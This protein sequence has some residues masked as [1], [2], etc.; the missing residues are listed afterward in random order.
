MATLAHLTENGAGEVWFEGPELYLPMTVKHLLG[1]TINSLLKPVGVRL[2]RIAEINHLQREDRRKFLELIR[3]VEGMFQ[4]ANLS[5]LPSR[6]GR[7]E[8][9]AELFGTNVSEAL[10][11][12]EY[13]HRA[14]RLKGDVCEFGV[15]QGATSTLMANEIRDT[16]KDLWLFDSF[17][18]LPKPGAKDELIDD[19]F[20]LK[21]IEKYE[22]QMAFPVTSVQAKLLR[23]SFPAERVKIVDG[24]IE[25]TVASSLLPDRVC[26]AYIDFDFYNPIR[27]ALQL[28]HERLAPGGFLVVDDYG[29]FSSG[30]KTAVDEFIEEHRDAYELT[31]PPK[32]AGHFGILHR[33]KQEPH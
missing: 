15:A 19:I 27:L 4:Q 30:A 17:K 24:F 8:L 21:S 12:L 5:N 7:T 6:E 9:L 20:N 18:G 2:T 1:A 31:L 10:Y 26:F 13:L 11:V 25:D 29:F 22:G 32:F 16:D 28:L 14:L 23:I 33:K 3:E